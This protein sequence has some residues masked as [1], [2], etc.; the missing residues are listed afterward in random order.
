MKTAFII[1]TIAAALPMAGMAQEG[2]QLQA[3]ASSNAAIFS[4]GTLTGIEAMS[5]SVATG[6]SAVASSSAG[7]SA[8]GSFAT[9]SAGATL[10]APSDLLSRVTYTGGAFESLVL[11]TTP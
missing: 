5:N 9:A 11:I 6:T 7:T 3:M 2:A 8:E 4:N 10:A 1:F